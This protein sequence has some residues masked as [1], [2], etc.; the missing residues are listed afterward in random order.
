MLKEEIPSLGTAKNVLIFT[1]EEKSI[2][3]A[4]EKVN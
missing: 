2:V 1:D 4:I 3:D